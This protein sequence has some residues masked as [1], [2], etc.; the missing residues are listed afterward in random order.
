MS[1]IALNAARHRSRR[2]TVRRDLLQLADVAA[3]LGSL[4]TLASLMVVAGAVGGLVD[5]HPA[6]ADAPVV[7]ATLGH[8]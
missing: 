8:R 7:Q 4:V 6:A 1:V 3:R 5:G 2:A